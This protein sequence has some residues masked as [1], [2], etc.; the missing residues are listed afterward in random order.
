HAVAFGKPRDEA[1][2]RREPPRSVQIN[3]WRTVT[4]NLDLGLDPFLPELEPAHV[5]VTHARLP[6]LKAGPSHK[7][8]A[9]FLLP[10]P[11]KRGE[12]TSAIFIAPIRKEEVSWRGWRAGCIRTPPPSTAPG[13]SLAGGPAT[14]G[15]RICR[16][17]AGPDAAALRA[18]TDRYWPCTARSASSRNATA[19]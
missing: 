8:N 12:G 16:P 7:S 13:A 19:P 5:D 14:S 6:P 4:R 2:I 15:L 10:S 1:A 3:E 18:R 9:A 17:T 11:A